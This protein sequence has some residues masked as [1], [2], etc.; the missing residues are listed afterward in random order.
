MLYVQEKALW[1][2]ALSVP[3][4]L[5]LKEM[6]SLVQVKIAMINVISNFKILSMN[7]M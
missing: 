5:H 4:L 6:D 7:G 2:A 1:V 3:V